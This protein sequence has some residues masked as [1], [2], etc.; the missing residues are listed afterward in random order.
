[1]YR[2]VCGMGGGALHEIAL[3]RCA[4]SGD[5]L[6]RGTGLKSS[7]AG[8]MEGGTLHEILLPHCGV[9]ATT[10]HVERA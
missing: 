2:L 1:M 5:N 3:P 10:Y 8:G 4:G 6:S 7:L 9:V